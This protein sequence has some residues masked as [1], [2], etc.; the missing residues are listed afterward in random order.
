M[1][2][3][4]LSS[5][6]DEE[7]VFRCTICSSASSIVTLMGPLSVVGLTTCSIFMVSVDAEGRGDQ[8][9]GRAYTA[10]GLEVILPA[11]L[12]LRNDKRGSDEA[13]VAHRDT[14]QNGGPPSQTGFFLTV[15]IS[16]SNH[17]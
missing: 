5:G 6:D 8:A 16:I 15:R 9:F 12:G 2:H 3:E 14:I 11:D 1:E 10:V 13:D 17:I 4:I 7:T